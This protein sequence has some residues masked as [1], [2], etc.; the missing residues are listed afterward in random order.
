MKATLATGPIYDNRFFDYIS[1]GAMRSASIVAPVVLKH[2]PAASLCDI[3]CGRGAWLVEWD[4]AGTKDYLGVDGIYERR[5][6]LDRKI[7]GAPG[8]PE[9]QI[10]HKSPSVQGIRP[11]T[12]HRFL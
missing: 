8:S 7:G 10:E 5:V 3:G 4:R 2:F 12:L 9:L 11:A 6:H 1:S